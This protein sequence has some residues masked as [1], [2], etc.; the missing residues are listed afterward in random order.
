MKRIAKHEEIY[1]NGEIVSSKHERKLKLIF[2]DND[3]DDDLLMSI[4]TISPRT[5]I[6]IDSN[7]LDIQMACD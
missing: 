5:D 1:A 3:D 4:S 7:F 2:V 6:K